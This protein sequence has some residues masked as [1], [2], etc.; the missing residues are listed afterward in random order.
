ML[1]YN[2]IY[3]PILSSVIDTLLSESPFCL[4]DFRVE[5]LLSLPGKP[6]RTSPCSNRI[7]GAHKPLIHIRLLRSPG[8]R[9]A[10]SLAYSV[11]GILPQ[12]RKSI[13]PAFILRLVQLPSQRRKRGDAGLNK[14]SKIS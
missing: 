12:L 2:A 13:A 11:E 8:Y 1:A 7:E 3:I 10:L 14:A 5:T 4:P 9:A 6:T